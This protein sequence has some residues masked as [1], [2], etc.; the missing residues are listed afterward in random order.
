MNVV[1]YEKRSP[2]I[3]RILI[4]CAKPYFDLKFNEPTEGEKC[5][6]MNADAII[7][8]GK[9]VSEEIINGN[10]KLKIIHTVGIGYD[11]QHVDF[12]KEHGVF[13][14]N[15]QGGSSD[16]VAELDI[17]LMIA[18]SRRIVQVANDTRNG[19]WPYWTYRADTHMITGK[20][21]GVIGAGG[22]GRA[23]LKKCKAFDM[24]T[25]YYDIKPI[26]GEIEKQLDTSRVS[27]DEL[28]EQADVIFLL[29][30]LFPS[31]YKLIGREQFRRMKK[32]AIFINDSRGECVDQD[33]LVE[34]LINGDIWGAALDVVYPEPL[35]KDHILRKL[36]NVILT[37]HAG[38]A[39]TELLEKLF[40]FTAKN[41]AKC[42]AG[43]RPENIVNGL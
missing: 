11:T 33:A 9:E 35:P 37:S 6:V 14:C 4:N 2:E 21:A 41:V 43:E 29:V 1:Y 19:E 34:A 23:V 30:P 3:E 20:T 39:T 40:T 18:L 8:H 31:T 5:S 25:V 38:S 13:V 27:L 24:K 32:S 15:C 42:L 12:A 16:C 7:C 22:I 36:P 28:L 26:P 17:G 10:P